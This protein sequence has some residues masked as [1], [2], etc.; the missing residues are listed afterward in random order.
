ML[1][2]ST[3]FHRGS[4]SQ[5]FMVLPQPCMVIV[6]FV[7]L[8][9]DLKKETNWL[10]SQQLLYDSMKNIQSSGLY[11]VTLRT[12]ITTKPNIGT[13]SHLLPSHRS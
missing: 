3:G 1:N 7:I 9:L 10:N 12:L 13:F 2:D 4:N 5:L 6:Q 8:R 11:I